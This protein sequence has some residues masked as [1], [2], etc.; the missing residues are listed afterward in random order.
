M[1]TIL[2]PLFAILLCVAILA[3]ASGALASGYENIG[4]FAW[5]GDVEFYPTERWV[6]NPAT[7]GPEVAF[8][9]FTGN[10]GLFLGT[11]DCNENGGPMYKQSFG[12]WEPVGYYSTAPVKFCLFTYSTSGAGNFNGDLAWD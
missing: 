6:T 8:N 1:K 10:P 7:P 11:H 5:S 12:Y 3:P 2:K 9:Q 4:G